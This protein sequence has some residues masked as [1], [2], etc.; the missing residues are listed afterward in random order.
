[1]DDKALAEMLEARATA[2][3]AAADCVGDP[4]ARR[5]LLRIAAA[6]EDQA[7]VLRARR[8]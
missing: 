2:L 3:R 4:D 6:Y 7:A 1:M 8:R 5:E